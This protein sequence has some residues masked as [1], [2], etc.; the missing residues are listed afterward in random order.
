MARTAKPWD[1]LTDSQKRNRLK[2]ER[3]KKRKVAVEG[4]VFDMATKKKIEE[5]PRRDVGQGRLW[6]ELGLYLVSPLSVFQIL[7]ISGI[8]S[9]LVYQFYLF[10]DLVTGLIVEFLAIIYAV[11]FAKSEGNPGKT[12]SG[13]AIL[14]TIV[15]SAFNLHSGMDIESR[16]SDEGLN[17]IRNQR[18]IVDTQIKSIQSSHDALP[19]SYVT[20]KAQ[21][22]SDIQN[23]SAQL[24]SLDARIASAPSSSADD[25]ASI[26]IRILAM[27]ASMAL[28]HGLVGRMNETVKA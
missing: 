24:S 6:K 20:R 19:D 15:F 8:V 21:M 10:D 5:A 27:L 2:N 14:V 23:L 3:A 11:M 13:C 7:A 28:I 4:K 17:A 1:E 26:M 25:F 12:F 22:R 9:Y 18:Q 16:S